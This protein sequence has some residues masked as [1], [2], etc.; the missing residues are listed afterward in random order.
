MGILELVDDERLKVNLDTGNVSS[1]TIV[2][3]AK[4]V[5]DRV[6]HL[7]VSELLNNE[8]GVVIGKGEVDNKGVFSVL[9]NTGYDGWLSLEQAVGGREDL[10]FSI[11]YVRNTWNDA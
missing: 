4:R 6:V 11:E 10:R 5:A 8:H 2:D 1:D 3:L 7:H 9:K